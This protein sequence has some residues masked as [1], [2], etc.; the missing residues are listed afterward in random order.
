L[1]SEEV[2]LSAGQLH[3]DRVLAVDAAGALDAGRVTPERLD[4]RDE[5]LFDRVRLTANA[6]LAAGES[7]WLRS[8][9]R[10][11]M[12]VSL[13]ATSLEFATWML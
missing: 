12:L 9:E 11:Q 4:L 7:P 6:V 13:G 10:S 3:A 1:G 5:F 8:R 2:R